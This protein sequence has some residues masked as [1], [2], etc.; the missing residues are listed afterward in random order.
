MEA[1]LIEAIIF[2]IVILTYLTAVLVSLGEWS[3]DE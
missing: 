1:K 3:G 2:V